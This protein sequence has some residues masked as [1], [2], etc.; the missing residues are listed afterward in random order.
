MVKT[1]LYDKFIKPEEL[2]SYIQEGFFLGFSNKRKEN[3]SNSHKGLNSSKKG[4]HYDTSDWNNKNRKLSDEHK[5]KLQEGRINYKI[6]E[7]H[8][9]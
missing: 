7:E 8:R 2:D 6:T 9:Q 5:K 1:S 3:S 4:N